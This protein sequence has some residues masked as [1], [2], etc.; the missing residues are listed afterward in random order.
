M[1]P[2]F[3]RISNVAAPKGNSDHESALFSMSLQFALEANIHV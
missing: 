2:G 1:L 3:N